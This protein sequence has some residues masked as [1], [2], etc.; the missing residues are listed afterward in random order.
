ME[1][2]VNIIIALGHSGYERDIEIAK[3]CPHVDVVVGGQS[4]TLLYTGTPPAPKDISE[5]PYPTIA[6]KPDGRKVPVLQ[7]YAY[8]KYLGKMSLEVGSPS[9]IYYFL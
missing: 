9:S 7:A 6:V 4:H 3:R 1:R 5:G 8:T 2:G